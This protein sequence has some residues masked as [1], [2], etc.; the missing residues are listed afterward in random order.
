LVVCV[1]FP[2]DSQI[3]IE[4]FLPI[5]KQIVKYLSYPPYFLNILISLI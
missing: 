4:I 2:F 5:L 1:D 3:D